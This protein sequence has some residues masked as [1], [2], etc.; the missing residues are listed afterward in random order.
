MEILRFL[1]YALFGIC[2]FYG[3]VAGFIA[4][5]AA[6]DDEGENKRKR[7]FNERP[8]GLLDAIDSTGKNALILSAVISLAIAG[9]M[10]LVIVRMGW[11]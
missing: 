11:E 2:L 1:T 6:L 8:L 5:F 4:P 7:P 9:A 3:A 10:M